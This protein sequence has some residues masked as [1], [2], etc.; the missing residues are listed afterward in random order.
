MSENNQKDEGSEF[1]ESLTLASSIPDPEFKDRLEQRMLKKARS[2]NILFNLFNNMA[3]FTFQNA[4]FRLA[5]FSVSLVL[6]VAGLGGYYFYATEV[7]KENSNLTDEQIFAKIIENNSSDNI[8]PT[9]RLTAETT[10][11]A[12]SSDLRI[13]P[14]YNDDFNYVNSTTE[15][16]SGPKLDECFSYSGF[17][18]DDGKF[19]S[20]SFYDKESGVYYSKY[21]ALD[22]D[23]NLYD[24]SLQNASN[25]YMYKG[26]DYA[27]ISDASFYSSVLEEDLNS[28][29]TTE[30]S[31]EMPVEDEVQPSDVKSYFG[32]D[33]E[34]LGTEEVDGNE[35]YVVRWTYD[36]YCDVEGSE[37]NKVVVEALVDSE[38][39]EFIGQEQYLGSVA[40][41][42][43]I[44]SV[45]TSS[46]TKNATL[47][48]VEAEFQFEFD[49]EVKVMEDSSYDATS[50][51]YFEAVRDVLENEQVNVVLPTI[52]SDNIE[53]TGM[54]SNFL[55]MPGLSY[56]DV[57]ADRSFYPAGELGDKLHTEFVNMKNISNSYLMS[58][59]SLSYIDYGTSK[60]LNIEVYPSSVDESE[61]NQLYEPYLR[62]YEDVSVN[63]DGSEVPAK[64]Y[65]Y[66]PETDFPE[67]S[68]EST[69]CVDCNKAS[70]LLVV[71][72]EGIKYLMTFYGFDD[73]AQFKTEVSSFTTYRYTNDAEVDSFIEYLRNNPIENNNEILY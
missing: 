19:I 43:L 73:L 46:E 15:F 34:V 23:G 67:G 39:Y 10:S 37:D 48:E 38:T 9:S 6:V 8:S 32:E 44:N 20:T 22:N 63:L 72:S 65:T 50:D 5:M 61:F 35:Y 16:S 69:Y 58:T 40:E 71:E 13:A 54:Y 66:Q 18:T 29:E 26:G 3:N 14:F 33:A 12:E 36:A 42:N 64:L 11:I 2:S 28:E 25:V 7:K 68:P 4:K 17:G 49:V 31:E 51:E 53:F 24:Y 59:L 21:K 45:K 27:T 1:L 70:Y 30:V 57:M 47:N 62:T 52:S 60:S 56:D 55:N 41:E